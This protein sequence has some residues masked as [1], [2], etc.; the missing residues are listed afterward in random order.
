LFCTTLEFRRS[1]WTAGGSRAELFRD[2]LEFLR[3]WGFSGG[4]S[5]E[6]EGAGELLGNYLKFLHRECPDAKIVALMPKEFFE[7]SLRQFLERAKPFGDPGEGD[8]P[9]NCAAGGEPVLGNSLRGPVLAWYETL[10]PNLRALKPRCDILLVNLTG[11]TIPPPEISAIEARLKLTLTLEE[12][13][14]YGENKTGRSGTGEKK[15]PVHGYLFRRLIPLKPGGLPPVLSFPGT[16]AFRCNEGR[17]AYSGVY[18]G[19]EAHPGNEPFSGGGEEAA[20]LG[21]RSQWEAGRVEAAAG[22]LFAVQAKFSGIRGTDFQEEQALFYKAPQEKHTKAPWP[23]PIPSGTDFLDLSPKQREFFFF[24]RDRCR[25]GRFSPEFSAHSEACIQIY[26]GELAVSM[27]HE[28]PW[29]HFLAL[30]DLFHHCRELFPGTG[31]LLCRWLLDFAVIYGLCAEALPLLIDELWNGGPVEEPLI[32]NLGD[33]FPLLLD[34]SIHHFF[35]R[36]EGFN[37]P[38]LGAVKTGVKP[39]MQAPYKNNIPHRTEGSSSTAELLIRNRK[40]TPEGP[41]PDDRSPGSNRGPWACVKALIPRKILRQKEPDAYEESRRSLSGIDRRLRKDWNRGIFQFFYPPRPRSEV[42][43]AFEDPRRFRARSLGESSYTVYRAAFSFHKPLVDFLSALFSDPLSNPLPGARAS[44]EPLSLEGELLEE[45]RRE[46]D[47]VRELLKTRE[48][49][50]DRENPVNRE[51]RRLLSRRAGQ[52]D[53][54]ARPLYHVPGEGAMEDFLAALPEEERG[55]L[56]SLIEGRGIG[57]MEADTINEAFT[58]RF[59]DL[60]ILYEGA[61]PSISGEY[62]SIL[63]KSWKFPGG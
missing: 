26:A 52:E 32:A 2:H 13:P 41:F 50:P 20:A 39:P 34:L 28:G 18:P 10:P 27:G 56:G 14:A 61:A 51:T 48:T 12:V 8:I 62:L 33:A 24:W 54:G 6:K 46:S 4:L 11:G 35:I 23:P 19:T 37:T 9:V 15:P 17:P 1:F 53:P 43:R 49:A 29:H 45:L 5:V 3:T 44:P 21:L 47:E 31:A 63:K 38:P 60:L 40:E 25:R 57:P 58:R 36:T 42:R 7:T 16:S 59:G 22:G 55:A 30:R